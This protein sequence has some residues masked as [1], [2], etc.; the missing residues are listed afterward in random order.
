MIS[1]HILSSC[2]LVSVLATAPQQ[3]ASQAFRT[4]EGATLEARIE[5][6]HRQAR[7]DVRSGRYWT[8]WGFDVKPGISIDVCSQGE[9]GSMDMNDGFSVTRGA[10][11]TRNVAIFTLRAVESGEIEKVQIFNL[12]NPRTYEGYAVY[13]LGKTPNDESVDVLR[14]LIESGRTKRTSERSIMAIG[15]HDG[16]RADDV[17]EG[18]ARRAPSSDA[19][20]QAVMALGIFTNRHAVLADFI[21]DERENLEVR[22]KS[23]TAIGVSPSDS[24]VSMLSGLY[25]TVTNRQVRHEILVAVA[26]HDG[27]ED[28]AVE[29]LIGV[30]QKET[31]RENKRQA[32]FW[33]GQK[34]GKRSLDY[35]QSTIA[36]DSGD[37]EVQKQAVFA[38]SQRDSSE[39][40]PILIKV[41][42]THPSLEVRKQAIFWMTQA[43]GEDER[44]VEFLRE[45][46]EK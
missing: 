22:K 35:L 7:S 29:F 40:V 20:E 10:P 36:A 25:N 26:I 24:A 31:D 13:W 46:L 41:A 8:A 1:G 37:V 23:A 27:S 28:Q 12:D 3:A 19:R 14:K 2:L 17:V 9:H 15:V 5:A 16:K 30:A 11:E 33:L 6:A 39:A 44:V 4:V 38:I 42:K 32:I 21:R 45:L 43:E 18:Y 34:A